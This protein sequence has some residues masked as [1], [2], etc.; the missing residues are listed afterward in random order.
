MI[1]IIEQ[2]IANYTTEITKRAETSEKQLRIAEKA[3]VEKDELIAALKQALDK[4]DTKIKSLEE[5]FANQI[6]TV[7]VDAEKDKKIKKLEEQLTIVRN[8][9]KK[10]EKIHTTDQVRITE[11]EQALEDLGETLC[12]AS[13]N[14]KELSNSIHTIVK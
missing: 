1:E 7:I 9:N 4:R 12:E 5:Q 3:L 10:W 13:D 2:A 8:V 11:L 14:F 6:S